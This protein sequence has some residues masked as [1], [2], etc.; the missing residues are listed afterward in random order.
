MRKDVA[1]SA[2]T[3][4]NKSIPE[5]GQTNG[6]VTGEVKADED[7][8]SSKAQ[9]MTLMTTDVDR[10][11]DLAWHLFALVGR[12]KACVLWSPLDPTVIADSP[13]EI[14][15]GSIFLYSL[16]G[17]FV[18]T[19]LWRSVDILIVRYILLLWSCRNMPFPSTESLCWE[20]CR[21][22]VDS[23]SFDDSQLNSAAL[24]GAQDNLMKARDERVA[25]M[26]EV[27]CPFSCRFS[28]LL[29]SS[30]YLEEFVCLK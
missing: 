11:S 5:H 7:D 17:N 4:S 9:I 15:I 14:V 25:L 8:F 13:I 16:L 1:S 3:S 18:F 21:R 27:C 23:S 28:S 22:H 19:L 20:D 26:N 29:M 2:A 10:V 30:R 24:P 6:S 12:W